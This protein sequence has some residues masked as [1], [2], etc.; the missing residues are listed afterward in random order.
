M[1]LE[2][3]GRGLGCLQMNRRERNKVSSIIF[4]T[5]FI[6][7]NYPCV[8]VL[9]DEESILEL[10]VKEKI[11]EPVYKDICLSGIKTL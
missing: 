2:L 3:V 9:C 8:L 4:S 6:I 11:T 1:L 7:S 5:E 10:E